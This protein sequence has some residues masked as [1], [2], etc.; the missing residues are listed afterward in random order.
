MGRVLFPLT[1]IATNVRPAFSVSGKQEVSQAVLA[2]P[3]LDG[4]CAVAL[5]HDPVSS[6]VS[7]GDLVF[8]QGRVPACQGN[9]VSVATPASRPAFYR[10][11]RYRSRLCSSNPLGNS[12]LSLWRSVFWTAVKRL[13]VS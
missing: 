11:A 4:Q 2:S 6:E 9:G 10:P 1:A 3:E 13:E 8:V 7:L 5:P 12:F